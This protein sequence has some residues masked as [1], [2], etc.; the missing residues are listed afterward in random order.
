MVSVGLAGAGHSCRSVTVLLSQ[1]WVWYVDG[2]S[3]TT[4][5]DS[6]HRG[7]RLGGVG[8]HGVRLCLCAFCMNDQLL[9]HPT[10]M[11]CIN[12]LGCPWT[13]FFFF[14]SIGFGHGCDCCCFF[15]LYVYFLFSSSVLPQPVVVALC[16]CV[17]P[18]ALVC[19]QPT[20]W[21][22]RWPG[23]CDHRQ[24]IRCPQPLIDHWWSDSGRLGG[25]TH[26]PRH[27]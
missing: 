15:V 10:C 19:A 1:C 25:R 9:M 20:P 6:Q 12:D 27:W 3:E 18:A 13:L 5:L 22:L 2:A 8:R 21:W 11:S 26:H 24:L 17:C 16:V 7:R 14:L 4:T 23:E